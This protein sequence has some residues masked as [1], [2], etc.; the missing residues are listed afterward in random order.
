MSSPTTNSIGA[1]LRRARGDHSYRWAA[2]QIGI[3]DR[4]Y[5]QWEEEY[6][7]PDSDKATAIARFCGTPRADV[8]VLMGLL[9]PLEGAKLRELDDSTPGGGTDDP[10][11]I[12]L[13]SPESGPFLATAA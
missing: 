4:M 13:M 9:T 6:A 5:K 3:T 1:L 10:P 2:A 11:P 8:L 12:Y 7:R